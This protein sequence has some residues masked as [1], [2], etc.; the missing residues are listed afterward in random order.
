MVGCQPIVMKKNTQG[1]AIKIIVSYESNCK[2]VDIL[3]QYAIVNLAYIV[4]NT[5]P[6]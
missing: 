5:K 2:V 3:I 4:M 6:K 1:Q